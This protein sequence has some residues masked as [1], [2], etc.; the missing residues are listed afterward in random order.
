MHYLIIHFVIN[1]FC[2]NFPFAGSDGIWIELTYSG[3]SKYHSHCGNLARIA[4]IVFLCDPNVGGT[5]WNLP[6]VWRECKE[7]NCYLVGV[8]E[9]W[10]RGIVGFTWN[11]DWG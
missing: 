6:Y 2:I 8:N 3:G 11:G 7:Q 10:E 1:F 5:V 4:R 9:D